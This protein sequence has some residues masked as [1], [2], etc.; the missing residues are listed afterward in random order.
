MGWDR[1]GDGLSTIAAGDIR[2]SRVGSVSSDWHI[3][4]TRAGSAD[5]S[6]SDLCDG[7]DMEEITGRQGTDFCGRQLRLNLRREFCG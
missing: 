7:Y 1:R 2:E 5:S 3:G 4:E 6:N